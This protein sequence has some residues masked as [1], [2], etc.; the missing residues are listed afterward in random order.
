MVG[1]FHSFT[2][3]RNN[4]ENTIRN[5]RENSALQ[6]QASV[7][8]RRLAQ[9]MERRPAV[10]AALKLKKVSGVTAQQSELM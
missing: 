6:H 7:K 3:L 1:V 4:Q 9:Q 8:N 5:L 10:M 2:W